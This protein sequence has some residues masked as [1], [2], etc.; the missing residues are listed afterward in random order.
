MELF[1]AIILVFLSVLAAHYSV[2]FKWKQ[3]HKN[4]VPD[5]DQRPW[6]KRTLHSIGL[7]LNFE[8]FW[9]SVFLNATFAGAS[10]AVVTTGYESKSPYD[11]WLS[12]LAA[13]GSCLIVGWASQRVLSRSRGSCR[14]M[15][16]SS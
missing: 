9:R 6:H 14:S 2:G 11:G 13:A 5:N 4:S 15:T 10:I 8:A 3:L 16:A 7:H 12:P 1:N